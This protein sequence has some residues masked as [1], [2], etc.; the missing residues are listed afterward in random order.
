MNIVNEQNYLLPIFWLETL[1][2]YSKLF[3]NIVT[4]RV[5]CTHQVSH[6][7]QSF[8]FPLGTNAHVLAGESAAA[9]SSSALLSHTCTTAVHT[10]QHSGWQPPSP[11]ITQG[12]V[13]SNKAKIHFSVG[14]PD[15]CQHCC[16]QQCPIQHLPFTSHF[17]KP[18]QDL[19]DLFTPRHAPCPSPAATALAAYSTYSCMKNNCWLRATWEKVGGDFQRRQNQQCNGKTKIWKMIHLSRGKRRKRIKTV[20]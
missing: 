11:G 12:W 2:K 13:L 18:L 5:Q 7:E 14:A 9:P 10:Y 20:P 19:P 17:R 15:V 4:D 1:S 16:S 6:T 8:G 3:F